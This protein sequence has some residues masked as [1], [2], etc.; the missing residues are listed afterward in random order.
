MGQIFHA[1]AYDIETKT[2]CV[3]DADKFHANCFA[4]SGAVLSIHY[5]LRQ[6]PYR[7]MWG[8]NHVA[9]DLTDFTR[10]EDLLG[11][12]T[13]LNYENFDMD[14]EES[15]E[16]DE[17]EHHCDKVK[18]VGDNSILEPPELARNVL[19]VRV[20]DRAVQGMIRAEQSVDELDN[21]AAR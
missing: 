5:L 18:F 16:T 21:R 3:I 1:C 19:G 6:K 17:L 11:I 7:V 12:S 20:L 9:L 8:G 2:C 15:F 13:Y 10:T 14:D 4:D